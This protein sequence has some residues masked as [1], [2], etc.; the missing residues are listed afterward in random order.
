M[1]TNNSDGKWEN[2]NELHFPKDASA[3]SFSFPWNKIF[4]LT[5]KHCKF[6]PFALSTWKSVLFDCVCS[7]CFSLILSVENCHPMMECPGTAEEKPPIIMASETRSIWSI[8]L[9]KFQENL[10]DEKAVIWEI[11]QHFHRNH[12]STKRPNSIMHPANLF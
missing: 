11:Y 9:I 2:H 3:D 10:F 6:A 8:R 1:H 12:A 4:K 5:E 7:I